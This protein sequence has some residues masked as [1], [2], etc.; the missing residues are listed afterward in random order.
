MRLDLP[1]LL[2]VLGVVLTILFFVVGYR[3][4][5]GARK[6]RARAA[7]KSVTDVLF[8]RLTLENEFALDIADIDKL[9]SGWAID[10]RARLDDMYGLEDL[11]TVLLARIVESDYLSEEQRKAVISRLRAMFKEKPISTFSYTAVETSSRFGTEVWLAVGSALAAVATSLIALQAV[12]QDRIKEFPHMSL[13]SAIIP[14]VT[15]IFIT[16]GSVFFYTRLRDSTRPEPVPATVTTASRAADFERA[17]AAALNRMD[18]PVQQ[19]RDIEPDFVVTVGGKKVGIE[20]RYDLNRMPIIILKR[21]LERL[22]KLVTDGS[23]AK[24][25][26]VSST[27]P[28]QRVVNLS[29]ETIPILSAGAFLEKAKVE[30]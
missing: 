21:I 13:N 3:Q 15:V 20:L 24:V 2:S 5:I 23:L 16:A 9:I 17:F 26:L 4:T 25:Y 19:S 10:S 27:E 28:A 22:G 30:L 14:A 1:T 12:S 6:E 29:T 8:R 7:N 11:E 18:V